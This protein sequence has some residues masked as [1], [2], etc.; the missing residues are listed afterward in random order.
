MNSKKNHYF[1]INRFAGITLIELM[2]AITISLI[3][4]LGVGSIYFNS[5]RTYLVQEEF[6]RLQEGA[7]I[8][9]SF[10]VRDIRMAG[11][12]GCAWNNNLN[13]ENYL[14][15]A[16]AGSNE[17]W[18]A[19]GNFLLGVTGYDATGSGPG[20]TVN[21]NS[22]TAGWV[23]SLPAAPV[24]SYLTG[25]ANP[26]LA[27]SDIII[28][29]YADGNGLRLTKNKD[30]ANLWFEDL[31]KPALS[32]SGGNN[33]HTASNICEGDIV[34]ITD[35]KKSRVFQITPGMSSQ[36]PAIKINHAATGSPG[37]DPAYAS[38]GGAS[39]KT[40][41]FEPEDSSLLKAASYA[42]FVAL[43]GTNAGT[44]IPALF[45]MEMKPNGVRQELITGVENMQILYGIDSEKTDK[46]QRG[47]GIANRYVTANILT[48]DT[49]NIVSARISLLL[50][51]DN[52]VPN[53]SNATPAPKNFILSGMTAPSGTTVTSPADTRLRKV[54]TTT[55]KMRNKGLQ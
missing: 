28:V 10:M 17:N 20:Q 13:F 49:D 24:P 52:E 33:C 5:K 6:A 3:L 53:K 21:L 34:M 7:R 11:Y 16:G 48:A 39:D 30:S 37:N 35:C 50:R 43:N 4:M 36:P 32:L 42:Y 45:R 40:N 44:G 23:S 51:T 54:F 55:I 41:D 9:M 12:V 38:W 2:V 25:L 26:P 31:G 18:Q 46:T 22:P 15:Q 29:R 27:G 8:A 19:S 1:K 47:D 14:D